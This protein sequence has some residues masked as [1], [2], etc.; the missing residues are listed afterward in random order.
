M[1]GHNLWKLC[2]ALGWNH[3]L[4]LF[5]SLCQGIVKEQQS[6]NPEFSGLSLSLF[7]CTYVILQQTATSGCIWAEYLEYRPD[8]L[9][10]INQKV[11]FSFSDSLMFNIAQL[12]EVTFQDEHPNWAISFA[13]WLWLCWTVPFG[14]KYQYSPRLVQYHLTLLNNLRWSV[15]APRPKPR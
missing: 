3:H 15:A 12:L 13:L 4:F 7:Q 6:E 14:V 10:D 8:S 9:I 2:L 5:H 11:L 1:L